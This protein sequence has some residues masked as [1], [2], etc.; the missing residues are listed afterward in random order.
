MYIEHVSN[1]IRCTRAFYFSIL[2]S[3]YLFYTQLFYVS[4]THVY[5]RK[6][7]DRIKF[8]DNNWKKNLYHN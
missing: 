1:A 8:V 3:F 5:F 4:E 2:I 7:S 6:L